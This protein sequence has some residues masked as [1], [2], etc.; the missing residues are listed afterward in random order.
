M[1]VPRPLSEVTSRI[2]ARRESESVK[3]AR[4][5]F[6]F[7][8]LLFASSNWARPLTFLDMEVARVNFVDVEA[9]DWRRC[10]ESVAKTRVRRNESQ[11]IK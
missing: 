4:P 7:D 5:F 1:N 9:F 10:F 11:K 8:V 6:L 2:R 3:A